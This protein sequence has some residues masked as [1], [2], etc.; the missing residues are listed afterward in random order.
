MPEHERLKPLVLTKFNIN[1]I[2]NCM[3]HKK[4]D[5][6][7]IR[8]DLVTNGEY[9]GCNFIS[10]MSKMLGKKATINAV[11]KDDRYTLIE[12]G[13]CWTSAMFED[14]LS[15]EKPNYMMVWERKEKN[16]I[17][18]EV[19]ANLNNNPRFNGDY[20]VVSINLS[21]ETVLFRHCKSIEQWRK[22]NVL[23]TNSLGEDFVK[24]SVVYWVDKATN[25]I[26]FDS[27]SAILTQEGFRDSEYS[28]EIMT[29]KSAEKYIREHK[30]V[31]VEMTMEEVCR[32]L[33]KN[34]KIVK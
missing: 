7:V 5:K 22:D 12:C 21:G 20:A 9:D 6:V 10:S 17:K 14:P 18:T 27:T 4:G 15:E 3:I 33:G 16:A 25:E 24:D 2:N 1:L 23:F 28:T 30:V 26:S 32:E 19:V 29:I 13:C 11:L 8:K 31:V 34:V